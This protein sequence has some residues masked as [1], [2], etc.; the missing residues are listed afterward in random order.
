MILALGRSQIPL[1]EGRGETRSQLVR[2]TSGILQWRAG[3]VSTMDDST[4]IKA[5][6]SGGHSGY[7]ETFTDSLGMKTTRGGHAEYL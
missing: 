6:L 5:P 4:Q 1:S 7:D 3:A 2:A